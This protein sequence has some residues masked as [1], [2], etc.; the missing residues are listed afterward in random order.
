[1]ITTVLPRDFPPLLKNIP[2]P[3]K[4]LFCLGNELILSSERIIAIV[5]TRRM[6]RSG[7]EKATKITNDLVTAGFI[8]ISGLALGIDGVAHRT[9]I[10][11]G[12]RTIAVLGTGVD[13][14]YPPEHVALYN[15]ILQHEGAIIS[16]LSPGTR[17]D[18]AHFPARNRIISGLAQAVVVVEGALKSGS[19]ITARLAL[20][21]GKDVFAVPG[22][23]GTDYLIEQGAKPVVKAEDILKELDNQAMI[24][25][26]LCL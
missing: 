7:E 16:E 10:G 11:S 24:S 23:E 9:A 20:D 1:M 4:T 2:D 8:I 14:I 6:T 3:P 18:R 21:Q 26:A 5:G 22:S 25:G 15:S 12:G 19:L 13:I 17:P